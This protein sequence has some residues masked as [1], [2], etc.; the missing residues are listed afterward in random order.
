MPLSGGGSADDDDDI[1][2]TY[3][4]VGAVLLIGLVG[5]GTLTTHALSQSTQRE[6]NR[7][8]SRLYCAAVRV[9]V[10]LCCVVDKE[11]LAAAAGGPGCAICGGGE[12]HAAAGR[13][14]KLSVCVPVR[15]LGGVSI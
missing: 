1:I 10:R 14:G 3:G 13:R 15:I 2:A 4:V 11:V 7:S 6:S 8:I 12:I 9:R 5:A